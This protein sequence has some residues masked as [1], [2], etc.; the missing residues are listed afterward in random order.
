MMVTATE[1]EVLFQ[2][3]LFA[4]SSAECFAL[5]CFI[6]TILWVDIIIFNIQMREMKLP[7]NNTARKGGSQ[8]S[9]PGLPHSNTCVP[10]RQALLPFTLAHHVSFTK[11]HRWYFLQHEDSLYSVHDL[12]SDV[13]E[14]GLTVSVNGPWAHSYG[15]HLEQ[16]LYKT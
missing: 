4:G 13:E 10:D 16:G 12:P 15:V 3:L 11:T 14:T 7:Y 5:S 9:H 6:I 1:F 8:D 2:Y